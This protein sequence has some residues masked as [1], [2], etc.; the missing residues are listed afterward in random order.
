MHPTPATQEGYRSAL[1]ALRGFASIFVVLYHLKYYTAFDLAEILPPL[2]FGYMGVDLFFVLSGL[3]IC[4]VYL[5]KSKGAPPGFW[6]KFIW[7]RIARLFPVHLLM[8]GL[9]LAVAL[10]GPLVS[11]NLQPITGQQWADW[12][13]LTFLFREWLLPT[14]MLGTPLLGRSAPS[15]SLIYWF[16]RS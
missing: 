6:G 13:S 9:M 12:F 7:L 15:F 5:K 1:N 11:A 10:V 8:M 4:H 14:A 16:S 3:I 2:R